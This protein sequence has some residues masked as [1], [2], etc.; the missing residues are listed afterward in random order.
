MDS[1]RSGL[2]PGRL[3]NRWPPQSSNDFIFSREPD[4]VRGGIGGMAPAAGVIRS[5]AAEPVS[6]AP[7]QWRTIH[8]SPGLS[9]KGAIAHR[10]GAVVAAMQGVVKRTA[11]Q[12]PDN[13]EHQ[14]PESNG[15]CRPHNPTSLRTVH[16]Q[17]WRQSPS[18]ADEGT[19]ADRE[20]AAA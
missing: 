13:G 20:G 7:P 18:L 17:G 14:P 16:G 4:H 10:N 6:A 1:P 9:R 15:W 11:V 12:V 3:R 19:A 8:A 2:R 5:E